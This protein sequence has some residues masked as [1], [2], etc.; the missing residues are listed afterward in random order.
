MGAAFAEL[1]ILNYSILQF[2]EIYQTA[3]KSQ[4]GTVLLLQTPLSTGP[5]RRILTEILTFNPF[6][7]EFV[8]PGSSTLFVICGGMSTNQGMVP[9]PTVL[10]ED[11]HIFTSI[12]LEISWLFQYP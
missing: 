11:A 7:V 12:H 2:L 1:A 10:S 4:A 8:F 3:G 5:F 9:H 6:R